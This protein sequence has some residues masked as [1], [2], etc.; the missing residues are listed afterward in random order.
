MNARPG[1]W[2]KVS[3][4]ELSDRYGKMGEKAKLL[5][6]WE[7]MFR[8]HIDHQAWE[9]AESSGSQLFKRYTKMGEERKAAMMRERLAKAGLSDFLTRL[10]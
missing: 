3:G 1:I 5:G 2:L 7:T 4:T 9:M 10:I 6:V 8:A